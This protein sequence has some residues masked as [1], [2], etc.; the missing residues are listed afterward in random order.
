MSKLSAQTIQLARAGS[1]KCLDELAARLTTENYSLAVL[2]AALEN[3]K[4]EDVSKGCTL[5]LTQN[6]LQRSLSAVDL[7]YN[8]LAQCGRQGAL[9][10]T[11]AS[12]IQKHF[13]AILAWISLI[14]KGAGDLKAFTSVTGLISR[15][16]LHDDS[17]AL[18]IYSSPRALDLILT[19]W[20]HE[21]EITERL[22]GYLAAWNDPPATK[23]GDH[24][25][26]HQEGAQTFSTVVVS[27]RRRL[28]PFLDTLIFKLKHF[29]GLVQKRSKTSSV[30]YETVR[31][32]TGI[33]VQVDQ[34]AVSLRAKR[35][36][37]LKEL[38]ALTSL[39][40]SRMLPSSSF[41]NSVAWIIQ[42]AKSN[43]N[44][45]LIVD[46]GLLEGLVKLYPDCNWGDK[47][48]HHHGYYILTALASAA[49]YPQVLKS[50]GNVTSKIRALL[51]EL[52]IELDWNLWFCLVQ[53]I[54]SLSSYLSL[55]DFGIL[56]CDN[57]CRFNS[58][59]DNSH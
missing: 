3:L 12:R 20:K 6:C 25:L 38:A 47:E 57:D 49:C 51:E 2:D 29:S 39:F 46:S 4:L 30:P 28:S 16:G 52:K 19:L 8:C 32:L 31:T 36:A 23:V 43:R 59:L 45:D 50:L 18:M 5:S 54:T 21:P 42:I 35:S 7:V 15:I 13:D 41:L 48:G 24:Y 1:R 26:S 27:S 56:T 34:Q 11:T 33:F 17:L 40:A 9:A 44:L 10:A 55:V 22:F 53:H 37:C 58:H 14:I